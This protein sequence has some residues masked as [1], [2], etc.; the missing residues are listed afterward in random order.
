VRLVDEMGKF[1]RWV[2]VVWN[3]LGQSW[4][5]VSLFYL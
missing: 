3:W 1:A 5:G 2:D 4:G